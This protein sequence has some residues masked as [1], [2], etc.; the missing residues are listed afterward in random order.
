MCVAN[1][2]GR[3]SNIWSLSLDGVGQI[4]QDICETRTTDNQLERLRIWGIRK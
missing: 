1:G 3:A 4:S 2:G